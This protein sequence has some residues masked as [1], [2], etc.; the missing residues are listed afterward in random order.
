[1]IIVYQQ[2]IQLE[3][4]VRIQVKDLQQ[5]VLTFYEMGREKLLSYIDMI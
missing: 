1:M 3:L 4:A 2:R 5:Y